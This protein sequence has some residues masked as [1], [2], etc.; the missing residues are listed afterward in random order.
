MKA[1]KNRIRDVEMEFCTILMG[2]G[3]K[4]SSRVI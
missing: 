2:C 4:D 3:M 1:R